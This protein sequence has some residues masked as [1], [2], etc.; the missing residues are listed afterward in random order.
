MNFDLKTILPEL[1]S[2]ETLFLL[3]WLS[4]KTTTPP[5]KDP[6]LCWGFFKSSPLIR[7]PH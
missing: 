2:L 5:N 7:F 3:A 4:F 1:Q 6:F